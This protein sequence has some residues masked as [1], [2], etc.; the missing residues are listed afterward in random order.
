VR[1]LVGQWCLSRSRAIL[2]GGNCPRPDKAQAAAVWLIAAAGLPLVQGALS[3][4]PDATGARFARAKREAGT[5]RRC[6][7][8]CFR[9]SAAP[10]CATGPPRAG[11]AGVSR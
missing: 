6:P 3:A 7:R 5:N 2:H 10:L 11:K 1:G 9:T 8:N 4:L